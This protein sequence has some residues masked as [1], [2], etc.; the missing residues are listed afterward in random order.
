[1]AVDI[2]MK[3]CMKA[4]FLSLLAV[5][6]AQGAHAGVPDG[7][8]RESE[9]LWLFGIGRTNA[10]DTYLTPYEYEGASFMMT[11][12]SEGKARWGKGCVTRAGG[13]SVRGATLER[14]GV[15]GTAWHGNLSANLAFLRNWHPAK[16][17]RLATGPM[18][19]CDAGFT[20][21]LRTGNNPG[22]GRV[23]LGVGVSAL[24]D[25]AFKIKKRRLSARV[26]LDAPLVGARFSPRYGQSY[27][28]IFYLRHSDRNVRFTHPLNAPSAR[29][30]ATLQVPLGN[31]TLSFGYAGEAQQCHVNG[32]K[33][34]DWNNAFVVGFVRRIRLMKNK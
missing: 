9:R 34:H 5:V 16:G 29:L 32:L 25:Y 11:H 7:A 17:L 6:C 26:M 33:H 13:F 12:R 18:M 1:M 30:T 28:E 4:V 14:R 8:V 31:A 21:M 24:A 27:Y 2:G 3:R 22:Q 23:A 15:G 10:L 19:T 20:Y